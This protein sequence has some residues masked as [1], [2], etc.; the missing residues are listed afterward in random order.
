VTRVVE[1]TFDKN[2]A[3]ADDDD[4]GEKIV[5]VREKPKR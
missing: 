5:M 2:G 1:V 3:G 4:Q